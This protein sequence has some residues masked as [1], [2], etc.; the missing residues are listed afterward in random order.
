MRE[1]FTLAKERL[2]T[3]MT[4]GSPVKI[5]LNFTIPIFIGNMFQQFYSM[6]D[7]IIVGKFVGTKALAA[8]G[9]VGTIMF[10]ILGFL[11]GLTAGFSVLTAQRFGAGDM[12]GMRKTVGTAAVL[13]VGITIVM[14]VGS[15]LAMKPLLMFMHTPE[16][17]FQDA[18]TYI[19]IICAGIAASVLYNLLSGVLRALGDS[20]TPLYFLILSAVL[21]IGL[22]L[23]LIL[24]FHMGAAGAAYATVVSQGVS[25]IG[26][27]FYIAKKVPLLKLH[28]ED[29][30]IEVYMAKMQLAIGLP[31]ALQYS[32]TA[33]GTMMV[34]SALNML[35]S[36]SVAAFTAANKIEQIGT[37]AYVALGTTMAT[38][39][40]QNMGAG[41]IKRIRKGFRA[42]TIIGSIYSV[43]LAIPMVTVGKYLVYFFVSGDV[44]AIMGQA[45]IYLKCVGIFFIPLTIVNV[46]R[47]GIQGMGY[48]LLPMMAGVAELVGRGVVA[49]LAAWKHSYVGACLA[50]PFAWVLAGGL[51]LVMYFKIMKHQEKYFVS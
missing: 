23:L 31:M 3:D 20:K 2:Q 13:S 48:G 39:C 6:A 47:N 12:A 30:R 40:A 50:S 10:L 35:G 38:Y 7:T 42:A 32:I 44:S 21:N 26:C 17:I 19:M 37:Q 15:M 1:G 27:L 29:F 43:L 41:Q 34:Q 51:L 45:D 25:G 24:V 8:V 28:R 11:Q 14:T 9:S 4:M 33:I 49:M 36:M 18:Y 22:D 5:I 46:Y 16:D